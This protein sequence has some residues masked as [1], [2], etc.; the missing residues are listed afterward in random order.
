M[1][2]LW[3]N[4]IDPTSHSRESLPSYDRPS[5]PQTQ[6]T[7]RAAAMSGTKSAEFLILPCD[8]TMGA[9]T[10]RVRTTAGRAITPLGKLTT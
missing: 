10:L 2:A 6:P 7:T 5:M 8:I 1:G 3:A 9:I 4:V